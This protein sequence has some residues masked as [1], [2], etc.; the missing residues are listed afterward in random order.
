[1]FSFEA[2]KNT[3]GRKQIYSPTEPV[4]TIGEKHLPDGKSGFVWEYMV[5]T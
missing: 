2:K 5:C 1:M 3:A 4:F